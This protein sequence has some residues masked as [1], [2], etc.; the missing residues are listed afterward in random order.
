MHHAA[1]LKKGAERELK[2]ISGFFFSIKLKE[3]KHITVLLTFLKICSLRQIHILYPRAGKRLIVL[4]CTEA[5]ESEQ[6]A[7][8]GAVAVL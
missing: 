2:K 5:D 1:N 4:V 7:H 6:K 3:T 8:Y